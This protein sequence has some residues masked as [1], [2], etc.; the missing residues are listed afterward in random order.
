MA[1][2]KKKQLTISASPEA[3]ASD[4]HNID[5]T[6]TTATEAAVPATEAT[7]PATEAAVPAVEAA[8]PATEAT[9]PATE[10]TAPATEAT[11]PATEATAPAAEAAVPVAEAVTPVAEAV[12]PVAENKGNSKSVVSM[13]IT[14]AVLIVAIGCWG[15]FVTP[16]L[17]T[18]PM[19]QQNVSVSERKATKGEA[20]PKSRQQA[21]TAKKP[22]APKLEKRQ[23]EQPIDEVKLSDQELALLEPPI[24]RKVSNP[25]LQKDIIV[26]QYM[27]ARDYLSFAGMDVSSIDKLDKQAQEAAQRGD[28]S[29]ALLVKQASETSAKMLQHFFSTKLKSSKVK[30]KDKLAQ[31][32]EH[33]LQGGDLGKG[34]I[35]YEK[36]CG[37]EKKAQTAGVTK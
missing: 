32:A 27:Y 24:Y 7:A 19:Q 30:D 3:V 12:T 29:D 13:A 28:G 14:A 9:A 16:K 5:L 18:K 22:A 37:L 34:I 23:E 1:K 17:G 15:Y 11:A 4:T 20:S 25:V 8:A 6:K 21:P 33:Y 26:S 35:T 36:A 31:E 10:A 2:Q